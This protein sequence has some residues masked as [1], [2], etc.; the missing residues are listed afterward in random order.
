MLRKVLE[1]KTEDRDLNPMLI[2]A[3]EKHIR[4]HCALTADVVNTPCVF[5][6]NRVTQILNDPSKYEVCIESFTLGG[7]ALPA[8]F[9]RIV[10]ETSGIPVSQELQEGVKN[11]QKSIIGYYYP[12]DLTATVNVYNPS[13]RRWFDLTSE[14][15]LYN[16]DLRASFE[17]GGTATGI[18]NPILL[19]VEQYI[20]II[21]LFR[22]KK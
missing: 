16:F 19:G 8:F 21:V 22:R 1:N 20:E 9:R 6:S 11:V 12:P 14:F 5:S 13:E 4:V 10:F 2:D 18:T 3:S 17:F 7:T 15:P